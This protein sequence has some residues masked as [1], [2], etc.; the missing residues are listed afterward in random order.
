M[1]Y[2]V[3]FFLNDESFASRTLNEGHVE[4]S[5]FPASTVCQ[6]AKNLESS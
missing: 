2:T 4:L 3:V 6:L 1:R 5:M